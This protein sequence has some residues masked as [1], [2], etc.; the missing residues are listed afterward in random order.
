MLLF[1]NVMVTN[2]LKFLTLLLVFIPGL[3]KAQEIWK[4]SFSVP[5][6]GI[7]GDNG[8]LKS[9]FSGINW[10]LEYPNVK[11][12]NSADYAKTTT[13]SGGRFEVSGVAGEVTW[14]SETID[15]SEYKNV[16][17]TLLASETGSGSNS[18]SKYL[19]AFYRTDESE[20]IPF[21]SYP[22]NSGN[23]GSVNAEQKGLNGKKLRVIVCMG[24]SY[25]ADK[26]ILDEI[27]VSGEKINPL[28][29]IPPFGVV[30]NEL[31]T[32]P[33]PV[34]GLPDA[35]YIELYNTLNYD[36]NV[37]NWI[38]RING[39][40]KKLQ[41]ATLP[42]NGFLV[43]CATGALE[44]L[45]PFG[46]TINVVG[47]QGLLNSGATI[48]LIDLSKK[49]MDKISY[50]ADWF[51]D[52][53]K[54][55]GGWSL[56]KID[57]LRNCNISDNWKACINP[58]GGT[59]ATKN[60]VLGAN[61]DIKPP[62]IKWVAAV[63]ENM[64]EIGFSEA[65]DTVK[66]K[67]AGTFRINEIGL[68]TV[69]QYT[70]P[71]TILLKF[72][73]NFILNKTYSLELQDIT[74]ECGNKLTQKQ[75]A[76]QWNHTEPG[77]LVI[78]EI[79]FNPVAGG[80]DYVEL[81]NRSEKLIQLNN[82]S[83]ATR[84][85]SLKLKQVYTISAQK[86]IFYPGTYLALTKDTLKV[87]PWFR[88]DC[89]ECF[90]QVEKIPAFSDDKG[91][92]VILDK[93]LTVIDEFSYSYQMHHEFIHN[94]EGVSLERISFDKP[95]QTKGNWQ[96]ASS[97]A[98]FGTPGYKNSQQEAENPATPKITFE[99]QSFSP[100]N[101]GYNDE[102]LIHYQ[103]NT[104]GYIANVTVFDSSGRFVVRLSQNELLAT[105][106]TLK[107]NGKGENGKLL[108]LGVYVVVAEIFNTTGQVYRFKDGV[109][110]TGNLK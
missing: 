91:T 68:P 10:T 102:Y 48:E 9:D 57:P 80:E 39:V 85:D 79:L 95:S 43:L 83:I 64:A 56:E 32:D 52:A 15:I 109:V 74:D 63:T 103:M 42:A 14:L 84:D 82:L 96:S 47:F 19:K 4:E 97:L 107:W 88:I 7:W 71:Q 78:S 17:I 44:S 35:E 76:L 108:A 11:L 8:T 45:K 94:P 92:V 28:P 2:I 1:V 5:E 75:A 105:E 30:I 87:F 6:K 29:P 90:A 100:D 104:P 23:W 65:V 27:T 53:G 34:V 50:S 98:G 70:N 86:R 24:N 99:P 3:N 36:I 101:D 18:S 61:P 62:V 26:V 51:A 40:E 67:T 21:E 54:A 58:K 77:D 25:A 13:T 66:I 38:L 49:V 69:I 55:S 93:N 37:E 110:L 89:R 16:S 33:V 106:G 60:S 31:M 72:D 73:R 20:N 81:F 12:V 41:K 22:V 59:P 46:N